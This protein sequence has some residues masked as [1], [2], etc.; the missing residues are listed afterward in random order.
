MATLLEEFSE[1]LSRKYLFHLHTNF[2]DGTSSVDEYCRFA[3]KNT[4]SDIVFTEHIRRKPSYSFEEYLSAIERARDKY[5]D[6]NIMSGVETK[7]LPGGELDIP[8]RVES[9]VQGIGLSCHRFPSDVAL[10]KKSLVNM[11]SEEK[12]KENVRVW[13]HPG[14]FFR[15]HGMLEKTTGLL[16]EMVSIALECGVLIERN[17]KHNLPPAQ[18]VKNIPSGKVVRGLDAH[19]VESVPELSDFPNL[20]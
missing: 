3:S 16:E 12:W 14:N 19:S 15:L 9:R 8:P 10:Y 6:I 11:F 1:L 5:S 20:A 2:A 17:A 7:M 13:L 4:C 18:I